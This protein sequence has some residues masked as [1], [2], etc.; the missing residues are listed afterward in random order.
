MGR[1]IVIDEVDKASPQVVAVLAS[2]AAR[3]EMTLSDGRKIRPSTIAGEPNDIIMHPS[4]RLILLANRPGF[5]FLG[6]AF[7]RVLGDAFSTHAVCNPDS[8]SEENV[9]SQLAP[10]L[11]PALLRSLVLAFG[12][13]RK[14]FEVSSILSSPRSPLT[15]IHRRLERS[16]T[17]SRSES[18]S[19][20]S[21]T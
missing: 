4:T 9:L 8:Q 5:P 14:A 6:N 12:D 1:V 7:L 13:L 17:P 11:D 19:P 2:L 3:G 10:E 21:A 20:S 15:S 18:F 16:P